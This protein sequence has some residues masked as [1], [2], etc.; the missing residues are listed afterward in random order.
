MILNTKKAYMAWRECIAKDIELRD[1]IAVQQDR[2]E[3]YKAC[4]DYYKIYMNKA[5][6]MKRKELGI[7]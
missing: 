5:L 1:K 3:T 6:H 4:R 2:H 7:R